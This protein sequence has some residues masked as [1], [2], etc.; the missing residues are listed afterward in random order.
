MF[1]PGFKYVLFFVG[2]KFIYIF[3]KNTKIGITLLA[4]QRGKSWGNLRM[5]RNNIICEIVL[6]L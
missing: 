6:V 4:E 5:K 1:M 3:K 2:Y